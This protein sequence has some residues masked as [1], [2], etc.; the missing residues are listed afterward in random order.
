ML[1]N[2]V[3]IHHGKKVICN[4]IE[5]QTTS[6]PRPQ[7]HHTN[8]K[9]RIVLYN[10][11]VQGSYLPNVQ[12]LVSIN[13]TTRGKINLENKTTRDKINL[14]NKSVLFLTDQELAVLS[15]TPALF[16]MEGG[17]PKSATNNATTATVSDYTTPQKCTNQVFHAMV[18]C[19][20][21]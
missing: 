10:R 6:S 20:A 16:D 4:G 19:K 18:M 17:N 7:Q 14:E 13:K 21:R 1:E 9:G 15:N 3:E 2:T 8:Y 11:N 12:L 5:P